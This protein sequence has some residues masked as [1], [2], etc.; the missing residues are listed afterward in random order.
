[1]MQD[2]PWRESLSA[3]LG[4][5]GWDWLQEGRPHLAQAIVIGL[6]VALTISGVR[7]WRR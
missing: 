5:L 6:V 1:M 7:L 3:V 2:L 4:S